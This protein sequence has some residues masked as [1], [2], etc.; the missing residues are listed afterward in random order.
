MTTGDKEIGLM[1]GK[2]LLICGLFALKGKM[3]TYRDESTEKAL[4]KFF[5]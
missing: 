4:R 2:E 3:I 5:A 1:I